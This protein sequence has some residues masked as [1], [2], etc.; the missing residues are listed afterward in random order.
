MHI[1]VFPLSTVLMPGGLLP[2]RIFEPRYTDMV[3]RCL[4][5]NTGFVVCLMKD[6]QEVGKAADFYPVGTLGHI[7]DWNTQPDG[8]LGIVAQGQE[9]VRVHKHSIQKD[10]LI[11]AETE[12]LGVIDAIDLPAEYRS[13]AEL[14]REVLTKLKVMRYPNPQ[15]S[16]GTWV[17]SRLIELMPLSATSKQHW[18]E[19]ADIL[20]CLAFL[21]AELSGIKIVQSS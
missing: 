19:S 3:A 18:L 16:N 10:Q 7:I 4:R 8:L 15:Y 17:A 13:L 20:E 1:P 9:R 11:V 5:E 12:S 14:L 21:K 2:L 6:G